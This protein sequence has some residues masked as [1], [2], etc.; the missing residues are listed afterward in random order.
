MY[1][2]NYI[3]QVKN[4]ISMIE[5]ASMYTKLNKVS[6][7]IYQGKC[8]HPK[9]E[10]KTPSFVVWDNSNSWACMKC[11]KGKKGEKNYG[12]DTIAFI[13]WIEELSWKE[14]V[15]KLASITGVKLPETKES[16]ILEQNKNLAIKHK[17][18]L[19][20]S[21]EAVEYLY[22]RGLNDEDIELFNI[23][24]DKVSNRISFPLLNQYKE[25]VGFNKRV[26]AINKN[27][28]NN[29]PKYINSSNS[30]I[31]NKSTYL[32]GE[33]LLDNNYPYIYI[34][35]GVFDVILAHKYNL[36]N[37][38]CTL[39][40]ALTESHI[41]KLKQY[42]AKYNMIPVFIYDND[43]AGQ[44]ALKNAINLL[45]KQ[46]IYCK[47]VTLPKQTD[48]AE[49]VL[50]VKERLNK[51]IMSN[52]I[53]SG[54]SK[55]KSIVDDYNKSL[56]ELKLKHTPNIQKALENVP[57][58]EIDILKDFLYNEVNIKVKA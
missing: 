9:H 2:S 11:H 28:T 35:E 20:N 41:N 15:L 1:A 53:T 14:A 38:V 50:E 39:G 51:Y 36:K 54:Y 56:Y 5:L 7:N 49:L 25:V 21:D 31:F 43:D 58:S 8:P 6:S 16:K 13:Q 10:D 22:N 29:T 30:D 57:E 40:T 27:N 33:H 3:E 17:K 45:D 52:T 48:L 32:Y 42:K 4:S 46:D 19:F 34:T 23:G 18:D 55:V 26:L 24:Y 47:I 44:T 12:S 37:I